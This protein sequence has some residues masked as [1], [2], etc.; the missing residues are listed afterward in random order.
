VGSEGGRSGDGGEGG[1]DAAIAAGGAGG[2]PCRW[3]GGVS[4]EAT[5]ERRCE[6]AFVGV[7]ITTEGLGGLS[8]VVVGGGIDEDKGLML[9]L[10]SNADQRVRQNP[11]DTDTPVR[12]LEG[13][14]EKIVATLLLTKRS[15]TPKE[16]PWCSLSI[17]LR[18][19]AH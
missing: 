16:P 3:S 10:R 4:L 11:F 1:G 17:Q 6:G 5:V 13:G 15:A 2:L 18:Q 8:E 12:F 14:V 19:A 9:C 7:A